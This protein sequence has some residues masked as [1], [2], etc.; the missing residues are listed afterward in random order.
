M[1]QIA[2]E[3]DE[4]RKASLQKEFE[5]QKLQWFS[6]PAAFLSQE[7]T[8]KDGQSTKVVAGSFENFWMEMHRS[9]GNWKEK[10][11]WFDWRNA[12]LADEDM[13]MGYLMGLGKKDDRGMGKEAS[14]VVPLRFATDIETE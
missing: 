7:V 9:T 3:V 10:D 11:P 5:A 6:A 4:K 12:E 1:S 14:R 8:S 13:R 2:L